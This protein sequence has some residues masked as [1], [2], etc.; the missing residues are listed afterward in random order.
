MVIHKSLLLPIDQENSRME[1]KKK[2]TSPFVL[3]A[4]I[5]LFGLLGFLRTTKVVNN[6]V[7]GIWPAGFLGWMETL[8]GPIWLFLAIV[9]FL[10]LKQQR[11][12]PKL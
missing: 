5:V 3:K 6:F 4:L 7:Q 8:A 10:R 2:I 12:Q 11:G 1:P 9:F